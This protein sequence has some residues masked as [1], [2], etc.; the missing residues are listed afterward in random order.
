MN[1]NYQKARKNIEF[2][3]L[4]IYKKPFYLLSK[5]ITIKIHRIIFLTF[6]FYSTE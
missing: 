1:T 5:F 2:K 3:L 6:L 4:T